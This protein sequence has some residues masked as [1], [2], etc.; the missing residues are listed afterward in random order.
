[1]L[2]NK[3]SW[4]KRFPEAG[5]LLQTVQSQ[6]RWPSISSYSQFGKSLFEGSGDEC[7]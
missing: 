6:K 5:Q 1:M 3:Q 7:R 2:F 4:L